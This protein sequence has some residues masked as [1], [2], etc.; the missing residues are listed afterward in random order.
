[1]YNN[2]IVVATYFVDFIM[3]QPLESE[4]KLFKTIF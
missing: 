2:G 1:M 4:N 3:I